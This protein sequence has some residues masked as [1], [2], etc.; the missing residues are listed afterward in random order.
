MNA[1]SLPAALWTPQQQAWLHAL[2]HTVWLY[3][4]ALTNAVPKTPALAIPTPVEVAAKAAVSLLPPAP[5]AAAVSAPVVTPKK[6][7]STGAMIRGL[8]DPLQLA[9]LRAGRLDPHR[10]EIQT[11]MASWPLDTLRGNPQ[12][13][14]A[15]W[16]QLRTLRRYYS[17]H[18]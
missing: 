6:I 18:D 14:R 7:A 11:L 16:P 12:A 4:S 15:F 13:K 3:G 8:P 17:Q 10:P 1:A 5:T 2:G 9:L